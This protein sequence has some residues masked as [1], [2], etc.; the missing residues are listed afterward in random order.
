[1]YA[2]VQIK[3]RIQYSLPT[4]DKSSLIFYTQLKFSSSS[5]SY[6]SSDEESMISVN[7]SLLRSMKYI[8]TDA[9]IVISTIIRENTYVETIE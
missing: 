2:R 3:V 4:Y 6:T 7:E 9:T 1:M 8:S 5:D